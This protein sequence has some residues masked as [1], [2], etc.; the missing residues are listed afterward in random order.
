MFGLGEGSHLP[1]INN[2]Y[3]WICDKNSNKIDTQ[4]IK[5]NK[6]RHNYITSK[7]NCVG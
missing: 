4:F 2:R 6:A 1:T 3:F 5:T 7:R